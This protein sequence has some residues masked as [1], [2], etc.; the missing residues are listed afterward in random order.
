MNLKNN[1]E[2]NLKTDY[3]TGFAPNSPPSTAPRS[4]DRLLQATQ[5]VVL[6]AIALAWVGPAFSPSAE[7]APNP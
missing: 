1:S 6:G 5:W 2:S 3:A 4:P 7:P